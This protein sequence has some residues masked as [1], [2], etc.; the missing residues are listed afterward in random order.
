MWWLA[1][2][3]AGQLIPKEPAGQE[4]TVDKAGDFKQTSNKS[5]NRR[6]LNLLALSIP[7]IR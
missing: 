3:G 7:V 2:K 1:N 6:D 5:Q 4:G